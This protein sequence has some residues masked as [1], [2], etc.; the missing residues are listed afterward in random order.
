MKMHRLL[1]GISI[2]ILMTGCKTSF[3]S[4][5][6]NFNAYYNT[7][8]NA[9]QSYQSGLQKNLDQQREY[10]PLQPIRIHPK[11][12]NAGA[13]D[14]DKA[15][16]K[17]ADVLRRYE[18]TK[19]VDDAIGLIGKSYYFRQE[20]FS[21]DQ[22][23]KELFVTTQ[24][25]D[26][27]QKSIIWQ[28]RVLLDMELYNEG[29]AFLSE[30]LTLLEGE[31]DKRYRAEVKALLAQ[32]HVKMEN[33]QV[34]ANVLSEA[35]PNL[36]K[37]EYRERG[38]FLL[39]QIYERLD[40]PEAAF[41]AYNKVQ[42]HYVEYRIQ[43]LSQRKKA[44]VARNL[45]RNEVAYKIFDDMVRDDKNLE[46]KAELDFELARTEH[47]RKNYKQAEKLYNNVLHDNLRQPAP[48]VAAKAYYGLAEIYRFWYDD[49]EKA[50]AY[51]DSA[52]QKN[53]PA[54]KLPEDF[55][56]KE[57]AESFGNY[58]RFKS[59]IALQDS[60]LHLGRLSPEAFDSVLVELR[61]KKIAEL[62]RLREQQQQQQNQLVTVNRGEEESDATNNMSNGFLNSNN[63][64]VQENV[65]Q[66]FY[67]I[68]GDRPLADNWRV[69]S[70]IDYSA[71]SNET[72]N[73]ESGTQTAAN[74]QQVNVTIDLSAIPFTPQE[75]DSVQ[76]LIA[77][78][79]Y[80]LG[81]L[82]FL[83][84]NLPDSATHYF[85]KAIKN[86]S[87]KNINTVSLYSLSE[88]YSIQENEE[89][90]RS[91]ARRLI[92]EYPDTEYARRVSEKFNIP[93]NLEHTEKIESP[94]EIY[95]KIIT[96]DSLTQVEKA[97]RLK[98]LS[99][100]NIQNRIAQKALYEAIQSYMKAGKENPEYQSNISQWVSKNQNWSQK[101][102]KFEAEKDSARATLSDTTI[103]EERRSELQTFIDST[104]TEPDFTESFPYEG[105]MWDSA[106]AAADTF[107]VVF[108]ES[109]L[110]GKVSK[111][112]E[113]LA[114]P[115]E[116]ENEMQPAEQPDPVAVADSTREG[117]VDC[118]SID[119][120]LSVRGGMRSFLN[121]ITLP[122]NPGI[123]EIAYLFRVNQRGIVDEFVLQTQEASREVVSAFEEV[124]E[125]ELSFEPVL[126]EGQAISV[127]CTLSFPTVN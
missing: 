46:Y 115:V 87:T 94:Y 97:G 22:K 60:L 98:T 21:A 102:E 70:M 78:Y 40:N 92:E 110:T 89:E 50:A 18:E 3:Q 7:Y 79:E 84:L 82:F 90:A 93:L 104:F 20:Y 37:K 122:E 23:F 108:K 95:N 32:H 114:L 4:K 124:I 91:Y 99:L 16:Q 64:V 103:T 101:A 51:Y 85:Q 68:W 86:P 30:Q 35:L 81:N 61:E 33:W 15:I 126:S 10:N 24:N 116:E 17:G 117:Y 111:I 26:M 9:Q 125:S 48:D 113:E 41:D 39:G 42:N 49:F 13:S 34:A 5:W 63:P 80:Q 11:P 75:Q 105:A 96:L 66:Q 25:P 27:Q 123:E 29:I 72:S 55:Q 67:A 112:K 54:E 121:K 19:W 120:K 88:L 44:E 57:L 71:I 2:L 47:E 45:G 73:S 31:W 38:Y 119:A 12:V 74:Q 28:G 14:F 65:K 53:V 56:A 76:E 58:A 107:L 36:E 109:N 59:Q 1:F 69:E 43:Y 62:E 83:S 100:N 127:E 6:K 52:A 106:R 8:Y 118:K 77:S